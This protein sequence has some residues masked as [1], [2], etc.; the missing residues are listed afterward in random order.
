MRNIG[1]PDKAIES[2]IMMKIDD[3]SESLEAKLESSKPKQDVPIYDE[4]RVF[5]LT[6]NAPDA[7]ITNSSMKTTEPTIRF[8][9]IGV[10]STGPTVSDKFHK[11]LLSHLVKH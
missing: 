7:T 8:P 9:T 4:S 3:I 2:K 5:E 6:T 1:D 10:W 11:N